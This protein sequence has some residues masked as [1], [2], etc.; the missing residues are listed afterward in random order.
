MNQQTQPDDPKI[1]WDA[2]DTVLLD[3]DGTILD[4]AFDNFFWLEHMPQVYAE[5]N[6]LSLQQSKDFLAASYAELEGTLQWYCLDFWSERL[7]LDIAA[8]KLEVKDKVSFRPGAIAFLE[9]LKQ[10]NKSVYLVTNAHRKTLEIK[11]LD[12]NFHQYFDEL[13][14]SHDFGFPKEDQDYWHR[15]QQKF[16][17]NPDKTMF[18]DDSVKILHA[19][20]Q[21]GIAYIYGIGQPDSTKAVSNCAPFETLYNFEKI[22]ANG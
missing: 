22:I 6:Q 20:K 9:F 3:M 10:Q 8:L 7:K 15:L 18:V 11:L 16:G 21:F 17:F 12:N 13:S 19:A 4:L 2:I 1:E 5:R 14:S